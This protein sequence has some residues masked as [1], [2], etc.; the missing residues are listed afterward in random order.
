M[1][2]KLASTAVLALALLPAAGLA[3]SAPGGTKGPGDINN[4]LVSD[5]EMHVVRGLLERANTSSS[6]A[7]IALTK[8][9]SGAV[10]KAAQGYI[11]FATAINANLRAKGTE[12]KISGISG[13]MPGGAPGGA[14]PGGGAGG[15]PGGP[16]GGAGGPP[17][18]PGSGG[19]GATGPG[20]YASKFKA[21]L[22]AASGDAF[23][24]IYELRTLEYLEDMER[25]LL[26]ES[27]AG[28]TPA[29]R[30][31]AA[32]NAKTYEAEA[33]VFARLLQGESAQSGPPPGVGGPQGA[34][35]QGAPQ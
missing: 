5:V 29:L 30:D 1:K 33:Q 35:A 24:E 6:F 25:T 14:P 23:D 3:Q 22:N 26:N 4:S 13:G 20:V 17:G 10:K 21:E 32:A 8:S 18:G 31:W 9:N 27:I 12:L 2:I 34:P 11:D 16:G 28:A 15:P 7:Q 19:R